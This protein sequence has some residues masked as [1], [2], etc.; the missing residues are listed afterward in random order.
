M[1]FTSMNG[2][3]KNGMIVKDLEKGINLFDSYQNDTISEKD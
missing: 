2:E 3:K 1:L